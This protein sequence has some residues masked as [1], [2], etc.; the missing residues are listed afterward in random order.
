MNPTQ[1][2]MTHWLAQMSL[3]VTSLQA[4]V[5]VIEVARPLEAMVKAL[6]GHPDLERVMAPMG[7]FYESHPHPYLGAS[8]KDL[9]RAFAGSLRGVS[10]KSPVGEPARLVSD[11]LLRSLSVFLGEAALPE[12]AQAMQASLDEAAHLRAQAGD[13]GHDLG[14]QLGAVQALVSDIQGYLE[15]GGGLDNALQEQF[16]EVGSFLDLAIGT[17]R[18]LRLDVSAKNKEPLGLALLLSPLRV[19]S[20]MG[21]DCVLT[22]EHAPK[23][24]HVMGHRVSLA[25]VMTNLMKNAREAMAGQET[26]RFVVKTENVSLTPQSVENLGWWTGAQPLPVD[27]VRASFRDNGCGIVEN[28]LSRIFGDFSSKPEESGLKRGHGLSVCRSLIEDHGGFIEVRSEIG[29]GTEFSLYLPR[30]L[31]VASMPRIQTMLPCAPESGLILVVDDDT[32]MQKVIGFCLQ[33]EGY[34]RYLLAKSAE[35]GL[36]LFR[37]H[38]SSLS[39]AIV[40]HQMPGMSG[41]DLVSEILKIDPK[42][43]FVLASANPQLEVLEEGRFDPRQVSFLTKPFRFGELGEVLRQL[44]S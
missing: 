15:R 7:Q 41:L 36:E 28:N 34:D 12:P 3:S 6:N 31:S 30:V 37:Q 43:R 25:R 8:R 10:Q 13:V 11:Q 42:F 33:R 39:A 40:D 27:Y 16:G 35:E 4:G 1:S 2:I 14:H 19:R 29:V 32:V 44:I 5:D 38:R 22:I 21:R 26:K 9:A 17:T 24:W 18:E 23:M 20:H